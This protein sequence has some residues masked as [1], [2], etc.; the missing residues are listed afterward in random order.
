[1]VIVDEEGPPRLVR[2]LEDVPEEE[3]PTPQP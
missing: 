3:M 2:V 1:M